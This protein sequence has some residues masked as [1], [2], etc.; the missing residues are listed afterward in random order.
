MS[1]VKGTYIKDIYSNSD[2]GYIVGILK[3]KETDLDILE[4][5]VDFTGLN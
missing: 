5:K 3:I 2:N 1:Y 4:N